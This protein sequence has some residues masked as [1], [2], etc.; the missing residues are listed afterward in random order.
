MSTS[1]LIAPACLLMIA[2]PIARVPWPTREQGAAVASDSAVISRV[3]AAVALIDR[4]ASKY[5]RT[6]HDLKGFSLEGGEL[7]GYFEG[8]SLRKL[9]A[10]HFGE[11]G[12]ATEDYYFAS[13]RLV[14]VLRVDEQWT[15][16]L[17]GKVRSRVEHRVYFENDRLIRHVRSPFRAS[18]EEGDPDPAHLL[19]DGHTFAACAAAPRAGS[20][21]CSAGRDG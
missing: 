3:R 15:L 11:S 20:S 16:P 17:S 21:A 12:R 6:K 19:E 7:T 2:L 4:K 13:G 8:D 5:R 10:R 18:P 1:I 14:F 9:H